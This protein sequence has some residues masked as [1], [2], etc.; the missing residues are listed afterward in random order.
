[1]QDKESGALLTGSILDMIVVKHTPVRPVPS[2]ML[3][4]ERMAGLK[5]AVNVDPTSLQPGQTEVLRRF[6]RSGGT[7]LTAPPGWKFPEPREDQITL[8][9]AE[10][11]KLDSIWKEVNSLTGRRNLGVRLFNVASMLSNLYDLGNGDRLLLQLVNYS[12]YPIEAV[13]AHLLGKYSKAT[14]LA[15]G[16]EPKPL[17][18]Y[19]TEE[20]TG[21]EIDVVHSVAALIIER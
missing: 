11:E 19:E 12:D 16:R 20:G 5:L 18:T 4:D 10:I 2:R 15:P 7:L 17:G 13:T 8:D 1:V 21:I 14:L 9:E 3:S 6:T